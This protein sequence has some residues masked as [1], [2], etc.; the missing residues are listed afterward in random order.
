MCGVNSEPG[1]FARLIGNTAICSYDLI[2]NIPSFTATFSIYLNNNI[3]VVP[4][5]HQTAGSICSYYVLLFIQTP[6]R[7]IHA[8]ICR[9]ATVKSLSRTVQTLAQSDPHFF[10]HPTDFI[11]LD[12]SSH[13]DHSDPFGSIWRGFGTEKLQG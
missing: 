12:L 1:I 4:G 5:G 9:F 10:Y 7:R 2:A 13:Y 8:S 6:L 3:L 11:A